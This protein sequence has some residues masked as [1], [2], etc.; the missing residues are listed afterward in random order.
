MSNKFELANLEQPDG[1][2]A[3]ITPTPEVWQTTRESIHNTQPPRSESPASSFRTVISRTSSG[4]V[5][6]V[7][8]PSRDSI[9]AFRAPSRTSRSSSMCSVRPKRI[10]LS[11]TMSMVDAALA[12]RHLSWSSSRKMGHSRKDGSSTTTGS[13][14]AASGTSGE[15]HI[16]HIEELDECGSECIFNAYEDMRDC[17]PEEF[18]AADDASRHEDGYS[19]YSVSQ[20]TLTVLI[21]SSLWELCLFA[22]ERFQCIAACLARLPTSPNSTELQVLFSQGGPCVLGLRSQ[23]TGRGASRNASF[24]YSA[25]QENHM[26]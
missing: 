7:Q 13:G 24:T 20:K 18:Q 21:S 26:D 23:T 22:I 3:A 16:G 10:A 14:A 6:R 8:R 1:R 17:G 15:I 9:P 4:R 5:V 11:S 2:V 25:V 12:E 19:T